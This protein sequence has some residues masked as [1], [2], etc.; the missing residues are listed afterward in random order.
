MK[1][2]HQNHQPT[3]KP[4]VLTVKEA[5]AELKISKTG[6]YELIRSLRLRTIKIGRSRRVPMSALH[7]YVNELMRQDIA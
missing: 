1:M 6:I 7:D 3:T 4:L 2:Q 5:A